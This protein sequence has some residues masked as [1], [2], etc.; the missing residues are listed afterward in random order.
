MDQG[1]ALLLSGFCFQMKADKIQSG[2]FVYSTYGTSNAI[3]VVLHYMLR[4]YLFSDQVSG[5][6]KCLSK[7]YR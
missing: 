2:G 6:Q 1:L 5:D 7:T 3:N 4:L